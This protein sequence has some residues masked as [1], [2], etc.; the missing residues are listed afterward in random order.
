MNELAQNARR[1]GMT[2]EQY[3]KQL[4]E[5]DLAISR[6]A[7]TTTFEQL[8]GPGRD[9]DEAELDRLVEA[10]RNRHYQEKSKRKKT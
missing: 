3:V 7:R 10:A 6:K 5:D 1:L 4:V 2:S 9:V 8:L